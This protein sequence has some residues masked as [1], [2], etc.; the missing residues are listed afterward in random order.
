M[1]SIIITAFREPEG[2]R[3]GLDAFLSQKLPKG[4]EILVVAPDAETRKVVED[5]SKVY[6]Q[7]KFVRDL[8]K[9]KPAALNVAFERSKGSTLI[10]T[11]G[12]VYA[13]PS[14]VEE[15]LKPFKEKRVGLVTGRPVSLERRD[16]MLGFWSHLLTD[17][18]HRVRMKSD[19]IVGSGYLMAI[20]RVI[21]EKVPE[22]A[23][24]D[25]A[26]I[27]N[28]IF[29]R[30]FRTVYAPDAKVF[31]KYP[32][33][34]SDWVK[35]KKRSAGGYIQL[36]ELV[37]G[38][39][40]MRSFSKESMGLPMVVTYFRN[41]RQTFWV[42]VLVLARLYL[43]FLILVDVKLRRKSFKEVWVRVESTK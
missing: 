25:D 20:R 31:V 39:E 1:I 24:A 35:Q 43:W 30:G 29:E 33:N 37:D 19:F 34:F 8:G 5:F 38:E 17:V 18:A 16:T 40:R 23:L 36:E 10:L 13:A 22:N 4:Y 21:V 28:V 2:V 32:D 9:G 15:L 6:P 14:A 41:L 26:V 27:S 7:V 12:D 11:D 3:K 42:F